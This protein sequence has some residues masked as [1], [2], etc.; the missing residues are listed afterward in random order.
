MTSVGSNPPVTSSARGAPPFRSSQNTPASSGWGDSGASGSGWGSSANNN[1]GSSDGWPNEP[2]ATQGNALPSQWDDQSAGW[3]STDNGWDSTGWGATGNDLGS[4]WGQDPISDQ[5]SKAPVVAT[6]PNTA[7]PPGTDARPDGGR[8]NDNP[9]AVTPTTRS[10]Q[11]I[12]SVIT[13]S[14]SKQVHNEQ[15]GENIPMVDPLPPGREALSAAS[16]EQSLS[17]NQVGSEPQIR[18]VPDS[19]V[20]SDLLGSLGSEMRFV[21]THLSP[22]DILSLVYSQ[23]NDDKRSG[24]PEHAYGRCRDLAVF[25]FA[26]VSSIWEGLPASSD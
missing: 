15:R 2:V 16:P 20:M 25:R 14:D 18:P 8:N 6:I 10:S 19:N 11:A 23:P 12:L 9:D 1:F 13:S 5:G 4:G 26:Q 21:D 24:D 7:S 3:G 22:E 17:L